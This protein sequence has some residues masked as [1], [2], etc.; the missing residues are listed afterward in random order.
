MGMLDRFQAHANQLT[1]R[2]E[3]PDGMV[4][5]VAMGSGE[6]EISLRPGALR[7]ATEAALAAK[8]TRTLGDAMW[9]LRG[10]Y[11]AASQSILGSG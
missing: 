8:I 5:V 1:A 3:S 2:A 6:V 9:E 4:T 11:R 10:Q 7:D